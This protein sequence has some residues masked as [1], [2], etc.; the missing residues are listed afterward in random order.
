MKLDLLAS[1]ANLELTD[2]LLDLQPFA[3]EAR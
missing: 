3:V 2:L 1:E